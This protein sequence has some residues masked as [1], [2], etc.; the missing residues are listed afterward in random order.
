[1]NKFMTIAGV[2]AL[3][4]AKPYY[5]VDYLMEYVS[6]L[7]DNGSPYATIFKQVIN[8]IVKLMHTS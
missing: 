8:E 5:P 2:A 3:A 6:Q 4:A 1:M 7:E